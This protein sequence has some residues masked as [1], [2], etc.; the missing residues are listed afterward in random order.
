MSEI[1]F[2]KSQLLALF[3]TEEVRIRKELCPLEE[4]FYHHNMSPDAPGFNELSKKVYNL[5]GE[6]R[7]IVDLLNRLENKS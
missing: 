2:S 7:L 6:E 5:E 1:S 4:E 3:N